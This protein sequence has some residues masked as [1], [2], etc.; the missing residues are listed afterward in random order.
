MSFFS[1]Q[2]LSQESN[3]EKIFA[4]HYSR[5]I[6]YSVVSLYSECIDELSK[7]YQIADENHWLEQKIEVGILLAEMK[8]KT[9]DFEE[10]LSILKGLDSTILFPKYHIKKLGRIAAIYNGITSESHTNLVY[11]D[12]VFLYL[13]SALAIAEKQHL[14]S[15]QAGLYNELGYTLGSF[16]IDSSLLYLNKA[17]DLFYALGDKANYVVSKTNI[18]RTYALQK[19]I[20]KAT[21]IVKELI[22]ITNDESFNSLEVEL[23]FY[24]TLTFYY[25]NLND[26]LNFNKWSVEK[27]RITAEILKNSST[28]KL[29]SFRALYETKRYKDQIAEKAK[30]LEKEVSRRKELILYFTIVLLL[31]IGITFLLLR[32]RKL[33]QKVKKANERYQMLL[34][35][36]NHRIKNNLQMIIS[37]LEFSSKESDL[38]SA[39]AFKRMSGKVQTI[40]ALHKLLYLNVHNEKVD[41]K[42]YFEEVLELYQSI[43]KNNVQVS[44]NIATV[45]IESEQIIYFGLIF[46]EMLSNSLEHNKSDLINIQLTIQREK[47][48]YR[49]S[50]QDF[51][52]FD[53]NYTEG[54]GIKLIQKLIGRIGAKQFELDRNSGSYNFK[55]Y[56]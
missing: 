11:T 41:L 30:E 1:F 12:S 25:L 3:E 36:S 37:M 10:G 29:N 23:E 5:A 18:F 4:D 54:T 51:S 16:N 38:Q 26:T 33:K 47:N 22:E 48:A 55:F 24:R 40:G 28:D 46:N 20:E 9:S 13:D 8:R 21:P 17:A 6:D 15:E 45:A 19:D 27:Y 14:S 39:L 52:E 43:N 34:V 49:F 42:S 2:L 56:V 7:A 31:G 53:S 35:E 32:E 50:Y 44:L